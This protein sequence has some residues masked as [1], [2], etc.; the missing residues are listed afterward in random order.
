MVDTR[1]IEVFHGNAIITLTIRGNPGLRYKRFGHR[2]FVVSLVTFSSKHSILIDRRNLWAMAVNIM[3]RI[4]V[5][6][7]HFF[8]P[9][10]F[11]CVFIAARYLARILRQR[12][13]QIT[14]NYFVADS[15]RSFRNFCKLHDPRTLLWKMEI[16]AAVI[17]CS[18]I[19]V[20]E[21]QV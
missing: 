19:I 14:L 20:R 16:I 6:V 5:S 9:G 4:Y 10:R 18:L 8:L 2:W 1:W 21:S 17:V 7:S 11:Q 13:V 15:S 3:R 12:K